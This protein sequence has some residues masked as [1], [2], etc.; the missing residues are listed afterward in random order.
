MTE[1]PQTSIVPISEIALVFP[2]YSPLSR[3]RKKTGKYLLL[4]GRNIKEGGL[5]TSQKDSYIDDIP[6]ESFR[7]AIAQPG[8]I[9]V[10]TLFDRRKLYVYQ[11]KDPPAVVN[12]SCAIMRAPDKNDYILSYLRTLGGQEQF[13]QD[14]S[15]ATRGTFI[16]RLSIGDLVK[17]QIPLLPLSELQRVGDDHIVSSTTDDLIAL[18]SVLKGKEDDIETLKAELAET[19]VFYQNRL[20]KIEQQIA[21][22]NLTS[23]IEHGETARLEFKASLRWNMKGNRDDPNVE[24][25]VLKT[26]AAFCNTEGGELLI[27]VADDRTVL[28]LAHD[29]FTNDDKFLLHLRNLITDKLVPIV[30]QYVD[31]EMIT[32]NEKQIC[33]IV[34]KKSKEGVW[35]KTEKHGQMF[36]VRSGPSS[37]ELQPVEAV[38]YILEH[39]HN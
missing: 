4:G 17:I 13:L 39:F 27:G 2:G 29:H 37:T 15:K 34:C 25:A 19:K 1:P 3:E 38:K 36:Y 20:S 12:N 7:R 33:R 5:V 23:R 35:L 32:L 31:Y 18:R 10:S 30:V 26:V 9:V 8:D 24:M 6:K 22:N 21:S 14:A 16:P 11:A 28:G